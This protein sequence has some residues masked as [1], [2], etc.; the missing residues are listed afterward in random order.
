MEL[1]PD[2]PIVTPRLRLRPVTI[3][4]L[5][6]MLT[7]R[8]RADVCRYLP[9]EPMTREVLT[10]RLSGGLSNSELTAE[11]QALTLG[12]E[13]A[14]SGALI[15]DVVLF[16]RSAVHAG[17]ELGYVFA[18]EAG[19]KGYATEAGAAVL[20]L[21]FEHL[22]LHRVTACLDARNDDSARLA[23][24]LGMRLEARLVSNEWFKGEWADELDFAMLASEWPGSPGRRLLSP[25]SEP[26]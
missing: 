17:G 10:A 11:G 13:L 16:F 14:E 22:G 26:A 3:D 8:S 12:V 5:D 20:A 1:R 25:R 9:F 2:Y 21:A 6:A 7:Y 23:A 4:D 18:P 24:R 15:G 19:G